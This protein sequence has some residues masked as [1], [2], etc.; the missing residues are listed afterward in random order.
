MKDGLLSAKLD[1]DN[2]T[3][4]DPKNKD[5]DYAKVKNIA[6]DLAGEYGEMPLENMLEM[7]EDYTKLAYVGSKQP[8]RARGTS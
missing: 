3:D 2:M 1:P 7:N 4:L 6:R 5:N 8:T